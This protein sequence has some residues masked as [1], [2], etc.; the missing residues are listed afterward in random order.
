M[1][2]RV[3]FFLSLP[4]LAFSFSA[5]AQLYKWVGA[6]GKVNY[7]D[8]PPKSASHLEARPISS[9]NEAV[10]LPYEL[11]Q[12]VKNMP[13][14]FYGA[15]KCVPCVDGKNFLKS[16]G[17]PFSEKTVSSS[18]DLDKLKQISGSTQVPVLIIG[19]QSLSGFNSSTWRTSLTQAG[20]P[21]TNRLPASYHF[22]SPQPLTETTPATRQTKTTQQ[23]K[24][25]RDPNGFQF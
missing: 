25:A 20:Y 22:S 3:F 16:N 23:E 18:N 10:M 13:V 2:L 19:R 21:E 14:T 15:D 11:A 17:I 9:T 7:G 12:A 24:P 8:T 1:T 5:Q 4:F 6:D